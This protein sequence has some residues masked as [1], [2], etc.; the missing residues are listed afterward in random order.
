MRTAS[1]AAAPNFARTCARITRWASAAISGVA[2]LPV[3]IAHTGSYAITILANCSGVSPAMPPCELRASAPPRSCPLSRSSSRSP[4]Q[5]IGRQSGFERRQR[6]L[7]HGL[8]GLAEVLPALAVADD[9]VRAPAAVSMGA[10]NLAGEGAFLGPVRGSARRSRCACPCAAST[11][12]ARFVKGGQI[13]ISQ[14]SDFSTS[15]RNFSKNA[16]VS[17]GVLYIFQLPAINGVLIGFACKKLVPFRDLSAE[18]LRHGLADVGEGSRARPGP[19]RAARAGPKASS[20]TYSRRV[21]GARAWSGR[22]RG[23]R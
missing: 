13:T 19:R 8:V 6:P 2:V 18:V 9:D 10:G 14:C 11:A 20:G 15:G 12:A 4:T 7:Q 22:S 16:V 17:A 5:T 3:P 21:V 23:R 1:A